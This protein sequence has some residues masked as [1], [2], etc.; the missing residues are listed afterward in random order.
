MKPPRAL[1]FSAGAS[2]KNSTISQTTT[3]RVAEVTTACENSARVA[4]VTTT[5]ETSASIAAWQNETF[6]P[7]TTTKSRVQHSRERILDAIGLALYCDL[8]VTR[9]NLS[10]A[11]RATEELAELISLLVTNDTDPSAC[12]EVA[13][14]QIVLAGI[15]AWHDQEQSSLVNEKMAINRARRWNRTGDGHGQHV[16]EKP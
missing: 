6:G 10:R 9:P 7:A 3:P 2:E 4:E 14:V 16:K 8:S 12:L 1:E 15:P 5:H 13:D 11:I